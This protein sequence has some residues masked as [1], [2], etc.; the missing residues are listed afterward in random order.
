MRII[1]LNLFQK[2][3]FFFM[4]II[5]ARFT[6]SNEESPSF[7]SWCLKYLTNKPNAVLHDGRFSSSSGTSKLVFLAIVGLTEARYYEEQG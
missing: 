2:Y 5:T 3:T 1:I 6:G 7:F 4:S